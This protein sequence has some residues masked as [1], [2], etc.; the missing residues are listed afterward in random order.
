MWT[1][2]QARITVQV[3]HSCSKWVFKTNSQSEGHRNSTIAWGNLSI[4][5]GWTCEHF[6]GF[7]SPVLRSVAHNGLKCPQH[8]HGGKAQC[9]LIEQRVRPISVW[10]FSLVLEILMSIIDLSKKPQV[11]TPLANPKYAVLC[12]RINTN[13]LLYWYGTSR[14]HRLNNQK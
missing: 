14:M 12:Y 10:I 11:Q 7:K 4:L 3:T 6:S 5:A 9:G 8:P 13:I 1:I 2:P